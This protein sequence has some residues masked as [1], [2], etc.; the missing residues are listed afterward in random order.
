MELFVTCGDPLGVG[1]ELVQRSR[2]LL[3]RPNLTTVIIGHLGQWRRQSNQ[4]RIPWPELRVIHSLSELRN[5]PPSV[6]G[7]LV[8]L[9]VA[10]SVPDQD[11]RQLSEQ[12]RGQIA[13]AALQALPRQS[14]GQI[15]VV[16][17]PIAKDSIS[18]AGFSF[19]G[20][21][22]Y[23]EHHWSAKAIMILAGPRLRVALA[24]NHLPLRAVP[25]ALS[26]SLIEHKIALF[27][28]SL[29]LDFNIKSP[30]IAVCGLNP[31]ASDNGLFGNEEELMIRPAVTTCGQLG[32][33]VGPLPADTAFY[34]AFNGVFDGVLAMYHDQGLGPLKTVHFSDAINLSGGLPHLR[35]SPD[36][37]PAADLFLQQRADS[38]S[39]RAAITHAVEWLQRKC[40]L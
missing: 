26:R 30:R 33:I 4:L 37:G 22:E 39:M 14:S 32:D 34:K 15:A 27:Y 17:A 19:P 28:K 5:M 35:V 25:S 12:Q 11:A 13:L 21:T 6:D 16:T 18:K 31:H 36:H 2:D 24:T 40:N 10:E 1:I 9:S 20:Q 29:Q 8:F 3:S 7:D 23:F 38:T